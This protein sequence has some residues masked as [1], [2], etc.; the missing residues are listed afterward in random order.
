MKSLLV[1]TIPKDARN[2]GSVNLG[3]EIVRQ[4]WGADV[5]HWRDILE[6]DTIR[7]YDRIGFNVFYATHMLNVFPFIRRNGIP[8]EIRLVAGGQGVGEKGALSGLV[9]EVYLG[10]IDHEECKEQITSNAV[11]SGQKAVIELSRGCSQRC[12]FCEYAFGRKFRIKPISLVKS[13]IDGMLSSGCRRINFMSTDFSGYPDLEELMD[14]A[15]SK[16]VQILNG[17]YCVSSIRR[18]M[19]W[20]NKLPRNFKLGVESFHQPTRWKAG[21]HFDDDFLEAVVEDLLQYA[22]A[23]HFYLIYGLPSD[24][25]GAWMAWLEKLAAIRRKHSK[26]IRFEFNITNFEPSVGTPFEKEPWV[27]FVEKE[28]FIARWSEAMIRL[29]F[30]KGERMGYV[31]SGGRLGRKELS[32]R[33]LMMLK[34]QGAEALTDRLKF[35]LPNGVGR[36]ISDKEA[37]AFLDHGVLIPVRHP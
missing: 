4:A 29:G 1:D 27:D 9:D 28:K 35:A 3:L 30:F 32:Y 24:D 5:C 31:N 14:Y 25:Y 37:S 17:D 20:A 22:S 26:P 12:R 19:P 7:T 33:M 36:S 10:E 11:I 18:I 13:Q 6:P 21:K 23:I 34:T 2:R 15:M 8:S 16:N